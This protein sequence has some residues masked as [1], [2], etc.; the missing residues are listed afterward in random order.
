MADLSEGTVANQ[1]GNLAGVSENRP[2]KQSGEELSAYLKGTYWS[3][4]PVEMQVEIVK[5]ENLNNGDKLNLLCAY[6]DLL[7]AISDSYPHDNS[8]A[9]N[10]GK[11]T[12]AESSS[13]H[14]NYL[15]KEK[16]FESV[17]SRQPHRIF[18]LKHNL[19]VLANLDSKSKH[20][21][22]L[23]DALKSTSTTT[24]KLYCSDTNKADFLLLLAFVKVL[25][26]SCLQL[27]FYH[28]EKWSTLNE[29]VETFP[30]LFEVNELLVRGP[31]HADGDSLLSHLSKFPPSL[32]FNNTSFLHDGHVV[33]F[34]RALVST[35]FEEGSP[36]ATALK[37]IVNWTFQMNYET[38]IK[39][40]ETRNGYK[41]LSELV[42]DIIPPYSEIMNLISLTGTF[43]RRIFE[44]HLSVGNEQHVIYIKEEIDNVDKYKIIQL[45]NQIAD[46]CATL[47]SPYGSITSDMN[48]QMS[49]S[50]SDPDSDMVDSDEDD[51]F[52]DDDH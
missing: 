46:L 49:T 6:P 21:A 38:D 28:N 12:V 32:C 24:R 19:V 18:G 26:P 13:I 48:E 36:A 22:I 27:T 4:L 2:D 3:R 29:L 17:C 1:A 43:E 42:P 25:K 7:S 15:S 5:Q 9:A 41:L 20:T 45:A 51:E 10:G 39:E 33:K 44:L 47:D 30:A 35:K 34:L 50:D 16:M 14:I 31:V 11:G 37:R 52:A 8:N 40:G 23:L